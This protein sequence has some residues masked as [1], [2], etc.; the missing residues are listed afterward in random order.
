MKNFAVVDNNIVINVIIAD[1]NFAQMYTA[2]SDHIGECF[3]YFESH[4][5]D[6]LVARIGEAHINGLFVSANQ[7]VDL[8]LLTV[9]QVKTYGFNS[10]REYK[11]PIP[12]MPKTVTMRQARLALLD[13]GK[14]SDVQAA[15]NSLQSPMKEQA[16]ITWDYSQDVEISNPLIIQLMGALGFTETTLENL[17]I[18]AS[19]L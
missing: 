12:L 13:A 15:I 7:A 14:L 2:S 1:D 3:E 4:E 16:Q 11:E 19:K 9:D 5:D 18:E 6:T 17:F 10:G 8:G